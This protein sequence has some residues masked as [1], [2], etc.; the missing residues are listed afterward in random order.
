MTSKE[1]WQNGQMDKYFWVFKKYILLPEL[2]FPHFNN[3][4][5]TH[6]KGTF[7]ISDCK[8]MN[9]Y[10]ILILLFTDEDYVSEIYVDCSESNASYLFPRK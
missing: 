4:C 3:I 2:T 6:K 9:M 7:I 5:D 8:Y 10:T 1:Q